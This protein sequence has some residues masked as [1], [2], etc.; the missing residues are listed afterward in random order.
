MLG[1]RCATLLRKIDAFT[2]K[3]QYSSRSLDLEHTRKYE[4]RP[5]NQILI[6]G[7]EHLLRQSTRCDIGLSQPEKNMTESVHGAPEILSIKSCISIF[8]FLLSNCFDYKCT[9]ADFSRIEKHK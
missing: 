8:D 3:F 6:I 2:T 4:P 7:K 5:L 1:K 9:Q